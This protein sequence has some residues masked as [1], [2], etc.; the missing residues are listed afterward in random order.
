MQVVENSCDRYFKR[1]IELWGLEVQKSLL[2]KSVLIV[3]SGGLGCSL[4]IALGGS[5]VGRIDF[6]DF[7]E[8][9]YLNLH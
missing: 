6:L 9:S 4:G 3:G 7:D 2:H 1:Q 8:V 5:G